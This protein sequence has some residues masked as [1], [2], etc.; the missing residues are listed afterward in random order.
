MSGE[1]NTALIPF[2]FF[3]YTYRD[4]FEYHLTYSLLIDYL[5]NI[6]MFMPIGFFIPLL[7]RAS[8]ETSVKSSPKKPFRARTNASP[9]WTGTTGN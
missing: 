1:H 5:G 6:V 2:R 7:W 4:L 9:S 3:C 8:D